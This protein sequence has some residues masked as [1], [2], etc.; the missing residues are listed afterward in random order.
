MHFYFNFFFYRNR[1]LSQSNTTRFRKN[2]RVMSNLGSSS[3]GDNLQNH[4]QLQ[5]LIARES[6]SLDPLPIKIT[7]DDDNTPR[8]DPL[9]LASYSMMGGLPCKPN[10]RTYDD[11]CDEHN[12]S[13]RR[14]SKT[15]E[16]VDLLDITTTD[17]NEEKLQN[18]NHPNG[19]LIML[20][21]HEDNSEIPLLSVTDNN[22]IVPLKRWRSLD[23]VVTTPGFNENDNGSG[24][25]NNVGVGSGVGCVNVGNL[26]ADKKSSARNSIRSWLA[27]LFNG[28]GLRS[29]NVSLRRGGGGVIPGYDVQSERE[30]IV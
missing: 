16:L 17:T 29:S 27:N 14:N 24:V 19:N 10:F 26:V 23:H 30:S 5:S 8:F 1:L 25:Y 22:C 7:L 21:E 15:E 9:L 13:T 6:R 11:D 20:D 3:A 2:A 18:N 12:A 28:S 4:E